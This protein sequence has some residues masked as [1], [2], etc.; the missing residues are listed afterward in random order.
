MNHPEVFNGYIAI[1]PSLWW[2][3]Q[4]LV[5]ASQSFFAAHRDLRADLYMAMGDEGREM[6][7]GAW[8]LSAVLE[9]SKLA[10]LRWQFKRTPEEDH[11][12][13]AYLGTYEGL[14]AIFNGYRIADPVALFEQGG[15][16]AFDR[17]Y[18]EVSKRL[19]YTVEV[20]R[21]TYAGMVWGLSSGGRFADAEEIGQTMLERDPKNTNTLSMLAEVAGM[22]KDDARAIGYLTQVLQLYPGNMRARAA[23][24]NYKVDVDKIVHSPRLSAKE[25]TSYVGKYRFNEELLKVVYEKDNLTVTTPAGKCELRALTQTR[26]YCVDSEVNLNFNKDGRDRVAGVTAEYP[27]HMDEYRKMK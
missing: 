10:N 12:T 7:G 3:D 25:M 2:D 27:D 9:E 8:R 26:F 20:P 13:I 23:L 14:E 21:E 19:G 1:S 11:G 5:K 22:Q 18:A 17:H 15:L 16:A 6:L 24:A 4:A